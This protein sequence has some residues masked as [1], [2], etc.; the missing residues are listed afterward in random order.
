M[1]ANL[2]R[3]DLSEV[4][5]YRVG[6]VA[7]S[8]RLLGLSYTRI[9]KILGIDHKTAIKAVSSLR[10]HQKRPNHCEEL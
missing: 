2:L 8:L 7:E 5:V 1:N 10:H 9:G 4:T 6:V 3:R